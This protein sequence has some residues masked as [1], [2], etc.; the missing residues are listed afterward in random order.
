M[1]ILNVQG[2]SV[3]CREC[4][5]TSTKWTVN[6]LPWEFAVPNHR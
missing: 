3:R 2:K 5:E 4:T 6:D 1:R